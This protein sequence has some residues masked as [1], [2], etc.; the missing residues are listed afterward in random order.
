MVRLNAGS[1][2]VARTV[3]R[4]AAGCLMMSLSVGGAV[5]SDVSIPDYSGGK[6]EIAEQGYQENHPVITDLMKKV[7]GVVTS[8]GAQWLKGQLNRQLYR[9]NPGHSSESAYQFFVNSLKQQGITERFSCSSFSCGASNFWANDVFD[10]SR[11]YGLDR[12]QF[13]YLGEKQ[14]QFFS[15]YTV[16]R[17]N[18][19]IY[20]LVDVFTPQQVKRIASVAQTGGT[21][22]DLYLSNPPER[23]SE[24]QA[25]IKA[26]KD[27][28]NSAV[29]LQTQSIR[30]DS[31]TDFDRQSDFL[32]SQVQTIRQTMLDKGVDANQVRTHLSVVAPDEVVD[33]PGGT[34]WLRV[35][36]F[37]K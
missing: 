24:I 28:K 5:A 31:I 16:K 26:L 20:A 36:R 19:R 4:V 9:V 14:G 10:I 37:Q 15:V 27:D 33:L 1:S 12:Y 32:K 18:G 25:L 23:A 6:Q 30:P 34:F 8:D 17:G 21:Y 22:Q 13:Y 7:N 11:L 2:L 35:F 3:K 29:I